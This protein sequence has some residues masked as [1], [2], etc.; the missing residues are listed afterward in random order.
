M[1]LFFGARAPDAL[2]YFGPLNKVPNRLLRKHLVFSRIP[3]APKEYVQDRLLVES[4]EIGEMFGDPRTHIYICGLRGMEGGVEKAFVSI[5]E[6]LGI[7][8]TSLRQT[9]R[10]EGRYHIE[11][12]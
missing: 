1:T 5:A 3:G 11:T 8:W 7:S 12:Y 4:E 6:S 9:M 10:E 2:P